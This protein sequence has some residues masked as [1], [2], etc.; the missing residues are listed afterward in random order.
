MKKLLF[1]FMVIFLF[2]TTVLSAEGK[3]TKPVHAARKPSADKPGSLTLEEAFR[4]AL[5][6]SETLATQQE[7]VVQAEENYKQAWGSILPA[8]GASYSY[9]RRDTQSSATGQ[10]AKVTIDQ[11]LFRGFRDFAAIDET[12][13]LITAQQQAR[14]WAGLQ[15]YRDVAAA[16][17]TELAAQKDLNALDGELDLYDRRIKD[18]RD[19]LAIGR[20]R[21][22][23]VLT[24]Q[25]SQAIL[26]AQREQALGD[27]RVAREVLSFLTGLDQ[28][29]R[30][31]DTDTLPLHVKPLDVY[32]SRVDARPDVLAALK[33][34]EAAQSGITVAR[35]GH[36]PSADLTGNYYGQRPDMRADGRWDAQITVT[37]PLFSGGIVSSQVR[38]AESLR[39][40]SALQLSQARRLAAEDIR[41][42]Y[43]NLDS[44]LAQKR[45]LEE[46]FR[47]SEENY[48]A[49]LQDYEFG[50]VNN[51]DV[52]TALSA[53][54]ETK[55][56][57]QKSRYQSLIDY[58][59]LD[60]AVADPLLLQSLEQP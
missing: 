37:L 7:L 26:K 1:C 51:L 15:L 21:K 38:S 28:E 9:L 59:Q 4:A 31:D 60:A 42:L 40:E 36:L 27:L 34:V 39:R 54:Q 52:L 6:R 13:T 8:V 16:F 17:Y 41:S 29:A 47:I 10:T 53:Y 46:A 58:S 3:N 25:S 55:R 57:L 56:S 12:R 5:R 18:L 32:Q 49:N 23:E 35:G 44:A 11:P 33:N 48:K 43:H 30:L 45:A 22:T 14:E 2:P 24:I 20:S 50:R 19:R